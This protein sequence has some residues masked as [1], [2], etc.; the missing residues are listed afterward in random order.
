MQHTPGDFKEAASGMCHLDSVIYLDLYP[1][2][3][4]QLIWNDTHNSPPRG[5][6]RKDLPD[7]TPCWIY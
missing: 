5:W 2:L 6:Q 1:A 3:A 4:K 7:G